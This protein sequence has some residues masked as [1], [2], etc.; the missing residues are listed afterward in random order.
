[1]RKICVRHH[2]EKGEKTITKYN[3]TEETIAK[4]FQ[5]TLRQLQ[6]ISGLDFGHFRSGLLFSQ[7]K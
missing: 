4:I 7:L 1:M 2:N 6:A 5:P 3:H